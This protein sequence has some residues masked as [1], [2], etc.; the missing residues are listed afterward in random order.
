MIKLSDV[1]G[2]SSESP[3]FVSLE[4]T[5]AIIDRLGIHSWYGVHRVV[6]TEKLLACLFECMREPVASEWKFVSLLFEL[7]EC[8][9]GEIVAKML[10]KKMPGRSI[11]LVLMYMIVNFGLL[12]DKELRAKQHRYRSVDDQ[13]MEGEG[14]PTDLPWEDK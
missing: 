4:T 12:K 5:D 2:L 8:N 10:E 3:L 9:L 13:W 1:S 14:P 7:G 11:R 6:S